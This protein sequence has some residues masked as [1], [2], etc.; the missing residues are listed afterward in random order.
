MSDCTAAILLAAG[1]GMRMK[2]SL[3]KILHP[4]CGR[5][6]LDHVLESVRVAGVT[7][8]PIVVIGV[9]AEQVQTVVGSR[10]EF[11]LQAERLGTAHAAL[12]GAEMLRGQSGTAWVLAGDTPLV[13]PETLTKLRDAVVTGGCALSMLSAIA[14]DPTGYG[15]ILRDCEGRFQSIVEEKDCTEEQRAMREVAI[16]AYCFDIEKMLAVLP[17]IGNQNAKGEYYLTDAAELLVREGEKVE[18][19]LSELSESIG[20]NDRQS[21]HEA[22]CIMRRG[23]LQRHRLGGATIL[24]DGV[25]IEADV[26]IGQDVVIYP[27]NVLTGQ[28]V[29][30]NGVTLLPGNRIANSRVCAGA[31]IEHSVLT[32]AVIGENTTVG[33]FAYLRPGSVIGRKCRVGDFVEIKNASIGDRTKVSHLAYIGD[34]NVGSQVN[35]GCGVVFSN[36]DGK[37]KQRCVVGDHAF[38]GGNVNLVAP[39]EVGEGAYIAAGTT[40]VENVPSEALCI[41]RARQTNKPGW[42]GKRKQEGKL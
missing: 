38:I 35:V 22:E 32:E 5:S 18:A 30:E 41:G 19:V 25:I 34:A 6:M 17:R 16:L 29:I 31:E 4:I 28:T 15:R 1:N 11:A 14:D 40:V 8:P 42:V 21:L 2:S 36:Y 7:R 9:G 20:I 23:I 3:P 10:A 12:V 27:G 26:Q 37:L 33:P 24:D 39:V 13:K